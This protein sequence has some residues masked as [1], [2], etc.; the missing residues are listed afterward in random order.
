MA[1]DIGRSHFSPKPLCALSLAILLALEQVSVINDLKGAK[2]T[3]K[4]RKTRN[5][6]FSD[7]LAVSFDLI[8]HQ[9]VNPDLRYQN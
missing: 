6:S 2:N 9:K 1:F 4:T 7:C 8:L 3:E 5:P